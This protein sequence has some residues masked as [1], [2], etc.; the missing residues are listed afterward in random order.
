MVVLAIL[1]KRPI[2]RFVPV[3]A[4]YVGV[5]TPNATDMKRILI[6]LALAFMGLSLSAQTITGHLVDDSGQPVAF[7]SVAL[8]ADTVL[9][10]GTSTG[11]DGAF[12]IPCGEGTYRL[13]AS[14][15]GYEK[16]IVCSQAGDL[17]TL[18]MNALQLREVEITADRITEEVD[19]FVVLPRQEEVEAAGRTLVLL[20]MLKL[21]GLK[22]DV[23]LQTVSVDGGTAILQI[24][25]KEVPLARLANLR[26]DQVKRVEYSNNPG[27]RYLDRGASGIINIM[28]KERED[29]G[30]LVAQGNTAFITGFANGYLMGSYHKGRSEVAL[31]YT[32]GYRNYRQDPSE[33]EDSY[34]DPSR[35][36]TRSLR[37]DLPF[38]YLTSDLKAEYTYQHDD[39]TM[40]VASVSDEF[41][42]K[43][44]EGVGTLTQTDRGTT[45]TQTTTHDNYQRGNKPQFDLFYTHKMTHG[46]KVELNVVGT[47][48][49]DDWENTLTYPD[50]TYATTIHGHG[51]ALTGEGVYC[52]QFGS[53]EL[54]SGLQYQHNFAENDYAVQ[55]ITTSMA[56]DNAY[57]YVEVLGSI[58]SKVSYSVGTG[59]KLLNVTDGVESQR[60]LR[61][62]STARLQCRISSR[63]SVTAVARYTPS[64]PSLSQLS[65]VFQQSDNVEG[66]TG[67]PGLKP[68]ET[69]SG[70]L[71]LRW[72][73]PQGWY[74]IVSGGEMHQFHPIVYS[75]SYDPTRDLFVHAAQ[76]AYSWDCLWAF[77][78]VGVRELWQCL[79]LSLQGACYHYN[80]TGTDFSHTKDNV[81]ASANAQFHRKGL[82]AGASFTLLPLWQLYGENFTMSEMEQ[83]LYVQYRWKGL[84]AMLMWLCPFNPLGYRYETIGLSAVH[85]YRHINWTVE[86]GNMVALGL[87]WQMDFGRQYRKS[88]KTLQNGGYDNGMVR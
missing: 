56:K 30:S 9:L 54:R 10:T 59:G 18:T 41:Y 78:E 79:T 64:L 58:G 88:E 72:T 40:F 28:L 16:L 48:S 8:Y 29:G 50:A 25:G 61:N 65:P 85:P 11:E 80:S 17:G 57:L 36:V 39:S 74:V 32:L 5:R 76:N 37:E 43:T 24:N 34:L 2:V 68:S 66:M 71:M 20:D 26:A 67:T 12:A 77:G 6:T 27:T 35:T 15:V 62:L 44:L 19:R 13:V 7:A 49:K 84:T 51:Y 38:W 31:E 33:E 4:Y 69:L 75:Y 83:T 82:M 21:P 73:H 3:F 23:A 60:Y 86:N 63:W 53:V 22:V 45:T 47:Y 46:Q 55:N 14:F 81:T 1:K 42:T 87:T 52:V 70:R